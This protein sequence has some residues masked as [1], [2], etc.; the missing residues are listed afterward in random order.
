[1]TSDI[2]LLRNEYKK[3]KLNK[4]ELH[5]DPLYQFEKWL[6]EA[7]KAKVLE[8]TAMTL[9][10]ADREGIPSARIVLLKFINENGFAFFTN[11]QSRKGREL[12]E[13]PKAALVFFW[14][15]L[16]RQVRVIGKVDKLS[17]V[18]SDEYFDSRP[19][20]SRIS[21][22]ISPQSRVIS[23][24]TFLE[25]R[26]HSFITKKEEI[27]RPENWGGFI[28]QPTEIEFWQGRENRLHDRFQYKTQNNKRWSVVRLAP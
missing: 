26:V 15:E 14:P 3:R 16:E 5:A 7:I 19:E 25:N 20:E 28:L 21:A 17:N 22:I 23:D 27:K 13:N 2:S 11:Y 4:E 6:E 9:A 24:R 1:M 18:I 10:T 8:P 12:S